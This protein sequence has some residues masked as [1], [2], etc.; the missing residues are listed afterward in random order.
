MTGLWGVS[1]WGRQAVARMDRD[2][3]AAIIAAIP[4]THSITV[5]AERSRG[6]WS[7]RLWR[8]GIEVD[9]VKPAYDVANACRTLLARLEDAA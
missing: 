4:P 1:P 2:E 3:R 8:D 5:A 6:V 7:V 9:R